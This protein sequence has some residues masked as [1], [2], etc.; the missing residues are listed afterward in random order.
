MG[1]PE[2]HTAEISGKSK[3]A[4]RIAMW[5]N[6]RV[7]F[8]TPQ[9]LVKDIEERRCNAEQ[10]V[11][12]VMDEAHRATG[13]H[14]NAVLVRLISESA[15]KFRLVGLS[16]TP[17]TDIKSIQAVCDTLNISRIEARTE[18]DPNV[19]QYIHHREE[20]VIIVKQPDVV[21]ILDKKFSQLIVPILT[22]LR[23]MNVS[24]RLQYDS[25]RLG[26]YSVLQAQ[27][28]YQFRTKDYTLGPQFGALRALCHARTLLKEHGVQMARSKLLEEER[29]AE[30][31]MRHVIEKPQ[32]QTLVN[33]LA[34]ASG[35]RASQE[36]VTSFENN[37]KLTTLAE[38]LTQHFEIKRANNESSRAIVFSQWRQS[39]GEVVSMLASLP[40][41]L[42]KPAQFIGQASKKSGGNR[43]KGKNKKGSSS[44]NT[45]AA[46][47]GSADAA[48]MNQAQQQR[49]LTQFGDGVYNVL[50][51]TCVGEEGLDVRTA[52]FV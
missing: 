35:Y 46:A 40:T 38:V 26:H 36:D 20:E 24:Q 29:A 33:D 45:N 27:Q 2:K 7:F 8:C 10:I 31:C 52:T 13:E 14:A 6:K 23:Q 39:V 18:E 28:D 30:H 5:E 44:S 1:I 9:T 15:A 16:A 32:Y 51:C 42:I 22:E 49:V 34:V 11:C 37:P 21:K 50:V 12:V 48:G 43:K 19:K 4:S 3:P 41:H 25:A 17:G 47:T